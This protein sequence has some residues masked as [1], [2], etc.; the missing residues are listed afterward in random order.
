MNLRFL[1]VFALLCTGCHSSDSH[2]G[3]AQDSEAAV[4]DPLPACQWC[5]ADEAPDNLR[6]DMTIAGPD[7]PG[8]RLA[9]T[10]TV[11]E[12]GGTR[13]ASGVLLYAYHTNA[14]GIYPKRGDETGN[15]RRHGYLRSWL[16]TNAQGQYRIRTIRPAAYPSGTEP[17]HIHVTVQEPDGQEDWIDSIVFDGDSLLTPAVRAGFDNRGGPGIVTLRR[18]AQGVWQGRRDILLER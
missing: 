6:W 10:G 12:S 13:P 7:E 9:I 5:G 1:I 8:E 14:E 18:N 11:Y 3:Y 15:G 16:R 4:T 17:A 2:E